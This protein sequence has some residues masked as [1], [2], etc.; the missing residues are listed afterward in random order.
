MT[1]PDWHDLGALEADGRLRPARIGSGWGES[2]IGVYRRETRDG[3]DV[4]VSLYL[5]STRDG[6]GGPSSGSEKHIAARSEW[7]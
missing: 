5:S 7:G 1:S 4:L 3:R 6:P 2:T